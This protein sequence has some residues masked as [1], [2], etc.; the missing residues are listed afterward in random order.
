M[1]NIIVLLIAT[2]TFFVTNAQEN[3]PEFN[4]KPAYVDSK[5]KQLIELEKSSYNSL[6]KAKGLFKAEAGYF[7]EG[8]SSPVK[9]AQQPELKFVVKVSP[10]NDPSSILDLAQFEVRKEQRIYITT[11]AKTGSTTSSIKKIT[12]EVKKIKDGY[13]YLIA[14]NL[15]KGEYFF[16]SSES[17][18]AFSVE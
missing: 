11:T 14:K 16:G 2:L 3:L 7:L 4:N 10:G 18:F 12:Y 8:K 9:I 5:S 17:M 6:A 13:Y 1:K 15:A